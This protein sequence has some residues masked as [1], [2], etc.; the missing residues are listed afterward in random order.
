[1]KKKIW[2][3]FGLAMVF[4]FPQH[5]MS[6]TP[7]DYYNAGAALGSVIRKNIDKN[8]A[9]NKAL[10]EKITNARNELYNEQRKLDS[11]N[12]LIRI[13]KALISAREEQTAETHMLDINTVSY[14]YVPNGAD[15]ATFMCA[16]I[17]SSTFNLKNENEY[18]RRFICD[19][20]IIQYTTFSG[21]IYD[22]RGTMNVL[23]RGNSTYSE[24]IIAFFNLPSDVD[25]RTLKIS[26]TGTRIIPQKDS[27]GYSSTYS[28]THETSTYSTTHETAK[29]SFIEYWISEDGASHLFEDYN[30][31]PYVGSK[32]WVY[33]VDN[34]GEK[35]QIWMQNIRYV[36]YSN[37]SF[38]NR[39]VI[40]D[41]A[42]VIIKFYGDD[43]YYTYTTPCS[44]FF[45]AKETDCVNISDV[46][47]SIP[48]NG[49]NVEYVGLELENTRIE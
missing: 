24:P 31:V 18:D 25:I 3:L 11:L 28:T 16:S 30:G 19:N 26:F 5:S 9:D 15:K 1:M 12:N 40:C 44:M 49:R 46:F 14:F 21:V 8:K 20:M 27:F 43:S 38:S 29:A 39:N 23:V 45:R 41:N 42:R 17:S 6:Q 32:N 10:D 7:E 48:I 47:P 36:C 4:A 13:A 34:K 33:F 35:V 37:E 22:R 2:I